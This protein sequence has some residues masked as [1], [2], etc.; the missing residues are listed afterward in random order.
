MPLIVIFEGCSYIDAV[1]RAKESEK[2]KGT[3]AYY[4]NKCL[5]AEECAGLSGR[6]AIPADS[7][8]E[9]LGLAVVL[10]DGNDSRVIDADVIDFTP[11]DGEKVSYYFFDLPVGDYTFYLLKT[12]DGS[13]DFQHSAL[14]VV[15]KA[16]GR[17]TERDLQAYQNAIIVDDVRVD[18]AVG[19]A[20]FPHSLVKMK[21]RLAATKKSNRGYFDINVNLDDPLFSHNMAMEGLYYPESFRR[22]TKAFYRFAPEYKEGTIPLIF[23]H[24]MGGTPRDWK[25]MLEHINMEHFTPYAV[26]YPSGE[27]FSKLA[28]LF[29]EWIMSDKIFDNGPMVI[30]AHSYGGVIVREAF[31][32]KRPANEGLFISLASPFG[33]DAKASE[34]VE[35][36]PYVL[37]A[38]RSIADNGTFIKRLYRNPLA[39]HE[40]YRLIF[41]Y[42]NHDKGPS[43][44]GRIPLKK[45]LR[46][47]AC[48]E[49]ESIRGFNEDHMSVI[50]AEE[51]ADY[52]NTLLYRFAEEHLKK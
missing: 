26:Y 39:P 15:T 8:V 51:T 48:R 16:S 22:K 46:S 11:V 25:F 18:P 2:I 32:L 7:P 42:N 40:E 33:G 44:D 37:P 52:I 6:I 45:Q 38:W 31:N 50:N 12:V 29:S 21:E 5:V 10:N 34:G 13:G 24:G 47:E 20:P 17:I 49:A 3:K 9:A 28:A 41:T 14:S 36:A 27:D 19:T 35:N 1:M 23:V 43:G 4:D 30:V